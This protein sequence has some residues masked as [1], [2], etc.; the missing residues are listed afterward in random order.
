MLIPEVA[1]THLLFESNAYGMSWW[2][3]NI[4]RCCE[5]ANCNIKGKGTF[6]GLQGSILVL[7]DHEKLSMYISV[8]EESLKTDTHMGRDAYSYIRMNM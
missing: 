2:R 8:P 1:K 5:E 6:R 3:F 7:R 4:C